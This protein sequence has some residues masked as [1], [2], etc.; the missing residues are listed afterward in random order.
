MKHAIVHCLL[1]FAVTSILCAPLDL[2]TTP[3][4]FEYDDVTI[5]P[6]CYD[7]LLPLAAADYVLGGNDYYYPPPQYPHYVPYPYPGY[8][9]PYPYPGPYPGQV[10]GVAVVGGAPAPAGYV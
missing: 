10:P 4:D 1:S 8:A 2:I 9:G 6:H 5:K 7:Y 3:Q